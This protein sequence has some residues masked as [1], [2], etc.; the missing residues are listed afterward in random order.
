MPSHLLFPSAPAH[1]PTPEASL[2]GSLLQ[3]ALTVTVIS[4]PHPR[5]GAAAVPVTVSWPYFRQWPA[6]TSGP[7]PEPQK[8]KP[9]Q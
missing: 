6:L 3:G 4:V 7:L 9:P 1:P 2:P 8:G 5:A